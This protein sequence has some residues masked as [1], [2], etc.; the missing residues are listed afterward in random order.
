MGE[1]LY[2]VYIM[3]VE[4]LEFVIF[5]RIRCLFY[6]QLKPLSSWSFYGLSKV[7]DFLYFGG[8]LCA[9]M[10]SIRMSLWLFFVVYVPCFVLVVGVRFLFAT[11]SMS[12]LLLF[13]VY[14]L[15]SGLCIRIECRVWVQICC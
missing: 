2:F 6:F 10:R 12:L 7:R 11:G 8:T 14:H 4:V 9:T 15:V 5:C 1:C 13:C 3:I